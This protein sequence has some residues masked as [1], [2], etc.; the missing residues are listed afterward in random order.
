[1]TLRSLLFIKGKIHWDAVIGLLIALVLVGTTGGIVAAQARPAT[2]D[3][4]ILTNAPPFGTFSPLA[5]TNMA[6]PEYPQVSDVLAGD[7][8]SASLVG[9]PPQ[10][11]I[12]ISN[13]NE[14]AAG[15]RMFFDGTQSTDASA[16]IRDYVWHFGAD[17]REG[18]TATYVFPK[19]GI[20]NVSLTVKDTLGHS[21]STSMV[22]QVPATAT[23]AMLGGA[24]EG[25]GIGLAQPDFSS[26]NARASMMNQEMQ[27]TAAQMDATFQQFSQQTAQDLQQAAQQAVLPSEQNLGGASAPSGSAAS[28]ASGS[29]GAGSGNGTVGL[30]GAPDTSPPVVDSVTPE[31]G[32]VVPSLQPEITVTFSDDGTM[33]YGSIH[34]FVDGQDVT[35]NAQINTSSISYLPPTDLAVGVHSVMFQAMDSA[36]YTVTKSWA[37]Q[38]TNP[39]TDTI[40]QAPTN[41]FS[42]PLGPTIDWQN[43]PSAPAG[44]KTGAPNIVVNYPQNGASIV[45]TPIVMVKGTTDPSAVVSIDG[46]RIIVASDGTFTGP[47]TLQ[48]GV[49]V[50]R[51][52]ATNASGM[53]SEQDVTVY[54]N[55]DQ[56]QVPQVGFTSGDGA[57]QEATFTPVAEQTG[58]AGAGF[59][60]TGPVI[61]NP[62]PGNGTTVTTEHPT[63]AF[64]FA[65]AA[66]IDYNQVLLSVDGQDV[67]GLSHLTQNSIS[68]TPQAALAEGAHSVMLVVTD[69]AGN[70]TQAD[71]NFTVA[72]APVSGLTISVQQTNHGTVLVNWDATTGQTPLTYNVYRSVSAYF[73]PSAANLVASGVTETSW[74]DSHVQNGTTYYYVVR[75]QDQYGNLSDPSA[76]ASVTVRTQ[77]PALAVTSPSRNQTFTAAAVT[78]NGV[79]TTGAQLDATLNGQDLGPVNQQSNGSFSVPLTLNAGTNSIVVTAKDQTG[80]IST[81][82]ETV[83][84]NPPD[85][86]APQVLNVSPSGSGAP[87]GPI[88]VTVN[89]A[90]VPS[91]VDVTITAGVTTVDQAHDGSYGLQV[92]ADGQTITY[93]P[94]KGLQYG[95]TYTVSVTAKDAAGNSLVGGTWTFTVQN[96]DGAPALD[97]ASPTNAETVQQN[98]VSV[99]GTTDP[100]ATVTIRVDNGQPVTAQVQPSGSFGSYVEIQP[101]ENTVVVVATNPSSGQQDTQA[102]DVNYQ[103]PVVTQPNI[104]I[105][106]PMNGGVSSNPNLTVTGD[107]SAVSGLTV[108]VNGTAQGPVSVSGTT[109]S[110]PVG[111][112]KGLN[113]IVVTG[114]DASGNTQRATVSVT[115]NQDAPPLVLL[116]PIANAVTDQ[117]GVEVRGTTAPNASLSVMVGSQDALDVTADDQGYFDVTVPVQAGVNEITV[118]TTNAEALSAS[119]SRQVTYEPAGSALGAS[120]G[121]TGSSGPVIS[122]TTPML[123]AQYALP[124]QQSLLRAVISQPDGQTVEVPDVTVQG[125][126]QP[127]AAATLSVDGGPA[128]AVS[129]NALGDFTQQVTL[130]QSGVN[131]ITL[132]AT[133]GAQSSSATASVTYDTSTPPL[134]IATVADQ[135]INNGYVYTTSPV[136]EI[137]GVTAPG[138]TVRLRV[139]GVFQDVFTSETPTGIY[140]GTVDLKNGINDLEVRSSYASGA[141]S[142]IKFTV[143]VNPQAPT[144]TIMTPL[145]GTQTSAAEARVTGSFQSSENGPF[146]L[147]LYDNGV[148]A[149]SQVVQSENFSLTTT[150]ASGMNKLQVQVTDPDGRTGSGTVDVI[151]T[152]DKGTALQTSVSSAPPSATQAALP[153]LAAPD[154]NGALQ[155]L[156]LGITA[157]DAATVAANLQAAEG[158]FGITPGQSLALPAFPSGSQAAQDFDMIPQ[159]VNEWKTV[160]DASQTGLTALNLFDNIASGIEAGIQTVLGTDGSG[161]TA[162]Y[163][164]SVANANSKSSSEAY[165]EYQQAHTVNVSPAPV[166]IP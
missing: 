128:T 148:S 131:T 104:A 71:M 34:L 78:L 84:Y 13:A 3:N 56:S 93:Q 8:G 145:N 99:Q 51:V 107:V 162:Q 28:G 152:Q 52:T 21:A 6:L 38:A 49:N 41:L 81:V 160:W 112:V 69:K 120:S 42:T 142:G 26:F 102:L 110:S 36:G 134:S 143:V 44:F 63:I 138:A 19:A 12:L 32:E 125:T 53:T 60:A 75:A 65:A 114:T 57:S 74:E 109:F 123:G 82:S 89:K 54:Y 129:P 124:Q 106:E 67:T 72:A 122:G 137:D 151:S 7:S 100:G 70:Q 23:G 83:F 39:Y 88:Q 29:T 133:Q 127:G 98:S 9:A 48:M 85:T 154:A 159:D 153:T 80:N 46:Q 111:L 37:F 116:A 113:Q 163:L 58:G 50:I 11:R 146:T 119:E 115:L 20:Y 139:N 73:T 105:T 5:I 97:V 140:A 130:T 61:V 95:G 47:A 59:A 66:G 30:L 45:N 77:G 144:V 15:Q 31:N 18:A 132:V 1:M 155:S 16:Q 147:N 62:V 161:A 43:L 126:V 94:T 91:T 96:N 76:V 79:A 135:A 10:P 35:G 157:S 166:I 24:G 108:T 17:V 101:G 158:E 149:S 14:L 92:S 90:I 27:S 25:E 164:N 118:I 40:A 64:S 4:A 2:P 156:Q 121:S 165:S 87:L 33:N 136:V 68:Y 150:L 22:L 55:Q 117:A 103:A 86:A 141:T